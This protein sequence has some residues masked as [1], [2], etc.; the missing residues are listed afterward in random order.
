MIAA[1]SARRV[2]DAK[3]PGRDADWAN[4][5]FMRVLI[6]ERQFPGKAASP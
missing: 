1:D 4:E 3:A 6:Q 2:A 5:P